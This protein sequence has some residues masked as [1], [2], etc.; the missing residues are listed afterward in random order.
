MIGSLFKGCRKTTEDKGSGS[1][2]R[3]V[4]IDRASGRAIGE[5]ILPSPTQRS[6]PAPPPPPPPPPGPRALRPPPGLAPADTVTLSCGAVGLDQLLGGGVPAG[7]LTLLYGEAGCGKTNLCL[8]LA[9]AAVRSGTKVLYLDTEGV[10]I[11]RLVQIAG[12][13]SEEG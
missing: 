6:A 3:R 4:P 2:T 10:S 7:A 8:Q 13:E 11:E 9:V 5:W 1:A 12:T